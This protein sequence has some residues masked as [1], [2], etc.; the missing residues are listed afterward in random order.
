MTSTNLETSSGISTGIALSERWARTAM[1]ALLKRLQRGSL[2][3]EEGGQVSYFGE[4]RQ[5][6]E[7]RA[8]IQIKDSAAWRNVMRG[9]CV[10]A[11][12]S[13]CASMAPERQLS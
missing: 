2:M 12:A 1:L 9:G 10:G 11:P 13:D 6:A 5:H 3:L 8:T 4:P 7:L